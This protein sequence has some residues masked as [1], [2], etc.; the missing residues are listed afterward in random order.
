[1]GQIT[2][3]QVGGYICITPQ[4][5][6]QKSPPEGKYPILFVMASQH[7]AHG[8]PQSRQGKYLESQKCKQEGNR[9]IEGQGQQGLGVGR[10]QREREHCAGSGANATSSPALAWRAVEQV[11]LERG[12][13]VGT[14]RELARS[15]RASSGDSLPAA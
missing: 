8:Q 12:Q 5:T 1:M 13:A 6:P 9:T 7:L 3:C 4:L 11:S 10:A 15:L 2:R 14:R